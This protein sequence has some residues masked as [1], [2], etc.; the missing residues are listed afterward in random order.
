MLTVTSEKK[1]VRYSAAVSFFPHIDADDF[2]VSYDAYY[3]DVLYE[4]PGRR[5]KK[6]EEL[7]LETLQEDVDVLCKRANA[8]IFWDKPLRPARFI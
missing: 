6:R 3:E 5:S 4:A 1:H 2:R 8:V 7:L